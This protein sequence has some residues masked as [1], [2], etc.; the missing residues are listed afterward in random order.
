[1]PIAFGPELV[2]QTEKTLNA[3]LLRSLEGTDLTEPQWVTLRLAEIGGAGDLPSRV[4]DRARFKDAHALVE[5]LTQRGLLA[6][7]VL[8]DEGRALV[9]GVRERTTTRTAALWNDLPE[10]DVAATERVLNEL[11]ERARGILARG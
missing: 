4:L 2:G 3:L 11:L 9:M 8:T 7:G 1:M 10:A 6:D 5:G